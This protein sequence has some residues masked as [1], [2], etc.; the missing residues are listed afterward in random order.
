[1]PFPHP[2]SVTP[3]DSDATNHRHLADAK[4]RA[5]LRRTPI[6]LHHSDCDQKLIP[7]FR[8]DTP[9]WCGRIKFW[10]R[11]GTSGHLPLFS[12][13]HNIP[14]NTYLS[15]TTA[16]HSYFHQLR[17]CFS[18]SPPVIYAL[19]L[20]DPMIFPRVYGCRV[21]TVTFSIRRR[22]EIDRSDQKQDEH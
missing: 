9:V 22:Q 8:T 10:S 18:Q 4:I 16:N 21:I 11:S 13:F 15:V 6:F 14:V 5:H 2:P 3:G 17:P 12:N 7:P 1:M 19:G 20:V